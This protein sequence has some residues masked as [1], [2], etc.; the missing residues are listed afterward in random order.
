MWSN[1]ILGPRKHGAVCRWTW[2]V[3]DSLS[4][5]SW[6]CRFA[7]VCPVMVS[8]IWLCCLLCRSPKDLE[9]LLGTCPQIDV[10]PQA[11]CKICFQGNRNT[12]ES[13]MWEVMLKSCWNNTCI[14]FSVRKT[15]LHYLEAD[16]KKS[17]YCRST[18]CS[19]WIDVIHIKRSKIFRWKLI[20]AC[21]FQFIMSFPSVMTLDHPQWQ[22]KNIW[23]Q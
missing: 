7:A 22:Y 3:C 11:T 16:R 20:P 6:E 17:S 12:I 14:C 10:C 1:N 15:F 18:D 2:V 9:C 23:L 19:A 8:G 5:T 21:V 4:I 13:F